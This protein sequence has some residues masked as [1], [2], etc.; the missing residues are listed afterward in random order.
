MGR[1]AAVVLLL[2]LLVPLPL[3]DAA[4]SS[5][6]LVSFADAAP[7]PGP[8]LG[9]RVRVVESF[10]FADV[11]LIEGPRG[12]VAS[13]PGVA[14]VYEEERV[15]LA[16]E[17]ERSIIQ[18]DA[19]RGASWPDG[20]NVTVALVDSGIDAS[21]PAFHGRVL[22]SVRISKGGA[23]SGDAGDP[24][25]HGTHVAGIVG[26][27]GAGSANARHRG[28]APAAKLVGVDISDSFTTT[29]AVRAFS[30]VAENAA[31]YDIRVV[32][33]SW[34]REKEG[35][36]YDPND[37]V[38]RASDALVE[39]GIVV[40]FSAGNR[41]R[42]GEATLTPEAMNPNVITVGAA[43]GAGR[44]ESYSSR[45]PAVDAKGKPLPWT[46][47]D[48]MAPGT[49]VVSTRAGVLAASD[50]SSEE[51]RYYTVMN[52]TS[53]AAP[54]VAAAAALLLHAQPQ[55]APA[56]VAALLQRSAADLGPLGVDPD[57]GYGMLDVAAA[58]RE[59]SVATGGERRIVV[60][61]RLPV[62]HEGDVAAALGHVVLA[63]RAPRLPPGASVTLPL[64]LPEGSA[65]VEL[66]FNW[67]GEGTFDARLVGPEGAISFERANAKSLRLAT[68]AAP[69]AYRIEATPQGVV[70]HA[71]FA[72]AGSI[73]VREEQVAD[74][75][76]EQHGR[77]ARA[78]G[79]YSPMP[80][81]E[82]LVKADTLLR[83][84]LLVVALAATAA[85]AWA[86]ARRRGA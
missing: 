34:G 68:G 47:P 75:A 73:V 67:S 24:D 82:P 19:P 8:L 12:L 78:G 66:W 61:K 17:R 4:A 40:V 59:A 37:P 48:L 45:G 57:T 10:P 26:G 36:Y 23:V 35:A 86:A 62:R 1:V 85:V 44:V 43:S 71:T 52:G 15:T 81:V 72:L 39:R 53:M 84:P 38:I 77:P 22:A 18:A 21:H 27:D 6:Y 69:G 11:A 29:N 16:M 20:G 58:L 46:K 54:Q 74:V 9:G 42:D 25:G 76:A 55:L 60:E 80:H 83:A 14:G 13:L 32:S 56:D 5:R 49:A 64:P 65:A 63:D 31:R 3:A 7:A 30:W 51:E 2:A 28:I 50:A 70:S 79:V 33:N 41:G